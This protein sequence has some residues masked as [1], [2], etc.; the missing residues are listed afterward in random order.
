MHCNNLIECH[1]I[2]IYITISVKTEAEQIV[3][4]VFAAHEKSDGPPDSSTCPYCY[5]KYKSY[6]TL[7][8]HIETKH[9]T[10]PVIAS[11]HESQQTDE[12][13]HHNTLLLRFL[14][15]KK[16]LDAAV[17]Y[18]DGKRLS[19]LMKLF[20]LYFKQL[21]YPK[22]ALACFEHTAQLQLFLSPYL[23]EVLTHECF[24]NNAG[25]PDSNLPIDLDIEHD[26]KFF[27]DH[28]VLNRYT[29]SQ[30]VIDRLSFAQDQIKMTL[31]NFHSQ[32]N[33][34]AYSSKRTANYNLYLNDIKKLHNFLNDHDVFTSHSSRKHRSEKLQNASMDPL[35][36]IDMYVI[37]EWMCRRLALM[38]DQCFLKI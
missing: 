38:K 13:Q 27:K 33:L 8:R 19:F 24:V 37:K 9:A 11:S 35:N 23:C 18:G 2:D 14:L 21:G 3:E 1:L 6:V 12:V 15:L 26:N 31:D 10:E 4:E 28:L 7:K 20:T 32:F 36:R 25:K 16:C 34:T 29:P 17:R 22:Y 5:R 30:L